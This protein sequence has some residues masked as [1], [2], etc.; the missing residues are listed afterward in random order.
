MDSAA[1]LKRA[2]GVACDALPLGEVEL[3][4]LGSDD[5]GVPFVGGESKDW[6]GGVLAV[7]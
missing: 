3:P 1:C 5:E 6:S 2:Q 4:G 7:S